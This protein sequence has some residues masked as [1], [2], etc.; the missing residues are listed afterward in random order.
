MSGDPNDYP[1][2]QAVTL[3]AT[4]L[5]TLGDARALWFINAGYADA[6]LTVVSR[7]TPRRLVMRIDL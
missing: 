7:P 5:A 3:C 2:A 6:G 1:G 4:N